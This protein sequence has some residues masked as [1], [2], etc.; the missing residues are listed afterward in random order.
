MNK[1][2][3]DEK[4]IDSKANRIANL[5]FDPKGF[6]DYNFKM[7]LHSIID[8]LKEDDKLKAL[9]LAI[10]RINEHFLE[11]KCS[12][13]ETCQFHKDHKYAIYLI[14]REIDEL[15]VRLRD[16]ISAQDD[17]IFTNEELEKVYEKLDEILYYVKMNGIGHELLFDEIEKSKDLATKLTS[18]DFK[19]L[20]LGI[21]GAFGGGELL[22][23]SSLRELFEIGKDYIIKHLNP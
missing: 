23:V 15:N 10:E 14:E 20:F 3:I 5:L 6:Y 13:P 22:N 18:K 21:L 16:N 17:K 9:K 12:N 19:L 8:V 11:H 1:I 7:N 2:T 4:I